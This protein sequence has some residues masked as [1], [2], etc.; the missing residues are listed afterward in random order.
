MD[1][2][3]TVSPGVEAGFIRT[4]QNAGTCMA[5][6]QR[7]AS[8]SRRT[9]D[10]PWAPGAPPRPLV[11]P[12]QYLLPKTASADST[13]LALPAIPPN[14]LETARLDLVALVREYEK[15]RREMPWGRERTQKMA[16]VFARMRAMAASTHPLL[17][18][19]AV[20]DSPGE[21]LA[22]IAVLYEIPR[23]EYV[24]WLAERP[25]AEKDFVGYHATLALLQA[26]RDLGREAPT[27]LH[28]VLLAA[29]KGAASKPQPDPNQLR[30]HDNA[31]AE[32][33][34]PDGNVPQ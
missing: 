33:N 3:S 15:I 31:L 10:R 26:V 19:L 22:A 27:K 20:S 8:V 4:Q 5:K 29:R 32:L 9:W 25:A 28:A 24:D 14:A 13:A 11:W 6:T 2:H 7:A 1:N 34:Q 17:P 23:P 21:R 30:T 18:S 12:D 16:A